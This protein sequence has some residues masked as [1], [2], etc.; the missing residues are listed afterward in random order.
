LAVHYRD[1]ELGLVGGKQAVELRARPAR[2]A[3][4]IWRLRFADGE[5]AERGWQMMTDDERVR[6]D[7]FHFAADRERFCQSRLLLRMVLGGYLGIEPAGVAIKLGENGKP[8]VD[9]PSNGRLHFNLAHSKSTALLAVTI[10]QP[11]G[12]DVE[13]SDCVRIPDIG[14]LAESVMSEREL[15]VISE[16]EGESRLHCFLRCWTRKEALVKA[17][18]V[19]L[20]VKLDAFTVP[21][22]RAGAWE[23]Q[24]RSDEAS[25][26]KMIQIMDLSEG[27]VFSAVAA[28]NLTGGVQTFEFVEGTR[29]SRHD[30]NM[31]MI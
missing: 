18:G 28:S 8:A 29:T 13:D 20:S 10:D 1:A 25:E 9:G 23:M 5:L 24:W 4:D 14:S 3:V 2:G 30:A 27:S 16:L 7:A 11:V 12:V 19:G 17:M 31:L 22:D 26:E 21:L 6:A 15:E